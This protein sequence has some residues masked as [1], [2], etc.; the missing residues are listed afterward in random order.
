MNPYRIFTSEGGDWFI[1]ARKDGDGIAVLYGDHGEAGAYKA[2]LEDL[3]VDVPMAERDMSRGY[4][5]P[6]ARDWK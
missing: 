6:K 4:Y 5:D 1:A 3:G 2:I